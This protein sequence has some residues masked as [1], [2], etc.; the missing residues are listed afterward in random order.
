MRMHVLPV[1]L[2]AYEAKVLLLHQSAMWRMAV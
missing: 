1:L 2:L